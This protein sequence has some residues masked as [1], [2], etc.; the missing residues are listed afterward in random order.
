MPYVILFMSDHIYIY[1]YI[2]EM[3]VLNVL[4]VALNYILLA[5]KSSKRR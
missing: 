5:T 3:D 4:Y 1:I 2:Q